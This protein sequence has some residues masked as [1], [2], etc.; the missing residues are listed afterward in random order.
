MVNSGGQ[1]TFKAEAERKKLEEK[2][3]EEILAMDDIEDFSD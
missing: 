1:A 3:Q 2:E